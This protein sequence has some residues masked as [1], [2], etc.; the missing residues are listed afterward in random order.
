MKVPTRVKNQKYYTEGDCFT[1]SP[2]ALQILPGTVRTNLNDLG[3]S[4]NLTQFSKTQTILQLNF[5]TPSA[6]SI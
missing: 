5:A 1:I 2:I 6:I 4:Y 3:F